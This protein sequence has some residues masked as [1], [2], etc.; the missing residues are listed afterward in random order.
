[1]ALDMDRLDMDSV[2]SDPWYKLPSAIVLGGYFLYIY[3][4]IYTPGIS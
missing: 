4:Y 1:M 2:Y 3:I